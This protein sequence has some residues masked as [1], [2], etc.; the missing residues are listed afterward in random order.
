MEIVDN[1]L[2]CLSDTRF[3]ENL[4]SIQELPNLR[5]RVDHFTPD[6]RRIIESP[7]D[8]D[9]TH[10]WILFLSQPLGKMSILLPHITNVASTGDQIFDLA[11]K[12]AWVEK[13]NLKKWEYILYAIQTITES[14]F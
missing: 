8:L 10:E 5:V 7:H 11:C 4:K 2:L 3:T 6:K 9:M 14:D 13:S 1:T 12:K